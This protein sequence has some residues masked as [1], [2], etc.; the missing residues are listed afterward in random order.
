[1]KGLKRVLLRRLED[2]GI[3][4][5]LIAGFMRSLANSFAYEPYPTLTRINER[6]SYMGWDGYELDYHT[7]ELAQHCFE[8]EG[9]KAAEHPQQL[10][11][12]CA[13]ELPEEV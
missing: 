13:A 9:L 10:R 12:L 2:K 4:P 1:M 5:Q 3:E 6:L 11:D 7:F 8:N